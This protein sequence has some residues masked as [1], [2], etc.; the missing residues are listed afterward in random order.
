MVVVVKQRS[1]PL[2]SKQMALVL[3]SAPGHLEFAQTD[4]LITQR[5]P[6]GRPWHGGGNGH[7][8]KKKIKLSLRV[9]SGARRT[10]TRTRSQTCL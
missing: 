7:L 8:K 6:T 9:C 1:G 4:D 3:L 10:R 5:R 2:E